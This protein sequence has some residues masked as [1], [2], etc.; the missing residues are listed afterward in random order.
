MQNAHEQLLGLAEQLR[1][2]ATAGDEEEVVRLAIVSLRELAIHLGDER[3]MD[4]KLDALEPDLA[5][6]LQHRQRQVVERLLALA[7]E[8]GL[9]DDQC[10][11]AELADDVVALL[12]DEVV[13]EEAAIETYHLPASGP[14]ATKPGSRVTP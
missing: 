10:R 6:D 2:A 4:I 8:P 5:A 13:A 11:C 3:L 1:S 12:G 7:D 14:R 9:A